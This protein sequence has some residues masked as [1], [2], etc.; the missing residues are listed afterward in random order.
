MTSN[1]MFNILV[2]VISVLIGLLSGAVIM[3]GFG[4]NPIE[5]YAALWEGAFGDMY[6]VGETVRQ[7]TPYILTGLAVAFAFRTGLFNIGAEGQVIV[8]WLAAIWVGITFDFP[9]YIHLPFAVIVAALAGAIWGF[10]PGLLKARLGVHEVIVTIMLN[11]VAL[12]SSNALIR[13]VLSDNQD[14]T[15]KIAAT[16]SL[17]SEW[18]QNLTFFSRMHYGILIALFAAIIM[19]FLIE[20]TSI[21]YELKSVGYNQHASKYAGMNVQRNIILA[22]VISGAFAGLAGAME[23]LGTYGN[24]SVSSGFTNL[25]FDGIA[26]ALLG[27]NTA[28]G[29]IL[30]AFLFGALKVG[31]L[32]MPTEA[33]VPNELVDIIIALIIFFVASSY[34][35]RWV[36]LRLKKGEK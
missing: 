18:L 21:G 30:A 4:Y 3:L 35:I 25:G 10:I 17:S 24:M 20:R 12:Y 15:D 31:A 11:Y 14:K 32:N 27:A 34:I 33:G 28:I 1:K 23:G 9:M 6:F 29:V 26:V 8:G 5:G 22:M 7:V 16:A 13:S 36:L 19:W 2:P